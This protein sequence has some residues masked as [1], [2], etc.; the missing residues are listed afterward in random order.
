[1]DGWKY[2]RMDGWSYRFPLFSTGLRPLQLP[3]GPLP[4]N[5]KDESLFNS[6]YYCTLL[7]EHQIEKSKRGVVVVVG[8][9]VVA[10]VVVVVA[11]LEEGLSVPP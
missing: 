1:M 5:E 3:P 4:K 8:V 7:I 2:I 9:V 6:L 11:S 10:G